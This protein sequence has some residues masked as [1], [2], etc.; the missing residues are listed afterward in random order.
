MM[1]REMSR[2]YSAE[3]AKRIAAKVKFDRGETITYVLSHRLR[4]EFSPFYVGTARRKSRIDTHARKAVGNTNSTRRAKHIR[5]AKYV[6]TQSKVYGPDWIGFSLKIHRTREDAELHER[7]LIAAF[8]IRT[9]G[10]Q[11]FNRRMTG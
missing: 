2:I 3:E 6:E 9:E 11:L 8:G 5:F 1:Q 10:G 4:D 7:A